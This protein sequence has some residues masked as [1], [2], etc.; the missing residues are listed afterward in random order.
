MVQVGKHV[1]HQT[2]TIDYSS[3]DP[4]AYYKDIIIQSGRG[5]CVVADPAK[6]GTLKYCRDMY[7][8]MRQGKYDVVHSQELFHS[9]IEM[10]LAW[11]AG[12]P[13]RIA[14]SHS[15]KDGRR[16]NSFVK[17]IYHKIMRRMILWFAT[18]YLACST[19]AG[20]FLYGDSIV[21]N[22]RFKVIFNSV[23]TAQYLT[24]EQPKM[25]LKKSESRKYIAHV[26]RFVDVKNHRF[27]LDI[28][29]EIK[30]LDLPLTLVFV[31]GGKLFDEIKALAQSRGLTAQVLFLGK[32][33]SEQ[34]ADVLRLADGFL[35]PS[36]YEGMPLSLIEAQAAGLPCLVA[37]H[38][39]DEVDFSLGLIYRLSLNA[40]AEIW[41]ETLNNI[42]CYPRPSKKQ[43]AEAIHQKGFSVS[44]FQKNIC[45]IYCRR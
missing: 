8:L 37:D 12:V 35:L 4:N 1:D 40:S 3:T 20:K 42:S 6:Q 21:K 33:P 19:E 29:D 30:K 2:L 15:T 27:M 18:D 32:L 22:K 36:F 5:F 24:E 43:I 25:M 10:F 44:D 31:G 14:H 13:R 17:A 16:R 41:A 38:I 28:A 39:T 26:G 7:C 9:G 45:D 34:V 11:L 23:D